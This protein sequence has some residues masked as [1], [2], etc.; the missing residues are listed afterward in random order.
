M[1]PR[2]FDRLWIESYALRFQQVLQ[3]EVEVFLMNGLI[4]P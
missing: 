3:A 1:E 4:V 2:W